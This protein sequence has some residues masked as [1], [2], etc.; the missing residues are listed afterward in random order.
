M[1]TPLMSSWLKTLSVDGDTVTLT[2]KDGQKLRYRGVPEPV[3]RALQTAGSP[4]RIW[5]VL[6]KG[7]YREEVLS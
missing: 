1:S 6:L 4:G 7:R 5:H 2:T 3:S